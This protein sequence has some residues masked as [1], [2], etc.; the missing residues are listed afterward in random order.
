MPTA[1]ARTA[2]NRKATQ[3]LALAAASRRAAVDAD[4]PDRVLAD[5]PSRS[6][7]PVLLLPDRR[8]LLQRVDAERARPR[9]RRRDAAPRRRRRPTARRASARRRGAAARPARASGQ[10]RRALGDDLGHDPARRAPRRPRTSCARTPSRPFG[11]IAHD[12][13][14]RDDRAGARRRR[15]RV[16]RV[17]RQRGVGERD[18]VA[19]V[20]RGPEHGEQ[21]TERAPT[22]A[23]AARSAPTGPRSRTRIRVVTLDRDGQ[24][25]RDRPRA[26]SPTTRAR[27]RRPTTTSP[28]SRAARCPTRSTG[29]GCT[30]ASSS[31]LAGRR[32]R[33]AAEAARGPRRSSPARPA[34]S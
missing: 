21:S 12:A 27:R 30:R 15:P 5:A 17:D 20:G 31:P 13:E 22:L 34:R 10:R 26:T 6:R 24:R 25:G 3:V 33:T 18:P 14:E 16:Q 11:V 2:N 23:W 9:T 1:L 19:R 4:R 8:R 7:R 29:S 28:S 32:R